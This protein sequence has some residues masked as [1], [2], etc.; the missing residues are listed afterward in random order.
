MIKKFEIINFILKDQFNSHSKL[1]THLTDLILN[2]KDKGWYNNKGNFNDKIFKLDW[3]LADNIERPW[4]KYLIND[5]YSQ[6]SKFSDS[7]GYTDI[8]INKI[9]YQLYK[10]NNIH[11]WHIHH[12]NFSGVYYLKLPEDDISNYTE[13]LS[14]NNFDVSFRIKVKEGD[15]I[16]FPSHL[17]HRAPALKK[18]ETK[19]IVS[20]NL[21]VSSVKKEITSDK[22][23]TL[24]LE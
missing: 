8:I 18:E 5:L 7:L 3:P 2:S 9:W 21:N 6:L 14:P 20:W 24:I 11:N 23:Q 1:K 13:F 10:K 15:I 17:I 22:N 19:I 16:F 12:D 4:I